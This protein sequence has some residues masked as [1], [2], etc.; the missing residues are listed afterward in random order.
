VT[1]I[2]QITQ[3]IGRE[4]K[5]RILGIRLRKEEVARKTKKDIP[6]SYI[7][8][9]PNQRRSPNTSGKERGEDGKLLRS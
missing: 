3:G 9:K 5:V 8:D 2:I 7:P 4:K 1:F 6:I